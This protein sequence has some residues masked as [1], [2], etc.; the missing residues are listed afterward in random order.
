VKLFG[1]ASTWLQ[2]KALGIVSILLVIS[3]TTA[4]TFGLLYRGVRAEMRAQAAEIA[5]ATATATTVAT[6]EAV[7]KRMAQLE[8]E[9]HELFAAGKAVAARALDAELALKIYQEEQKREATIG[10]CLVQSLSPATRDR[11]RRLEDGYADSRS[12]VRKES[13]P[14]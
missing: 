2:A 4:L 11:L 3:V 5:A 9:R 6:S 7:G 14:S 10:G 8:K 13:D 1:A 12:D